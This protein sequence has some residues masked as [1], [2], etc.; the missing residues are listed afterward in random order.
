MDLLTQADVRFVP[1]TNPGDTHV[2]LFMPTHRFGSEVQGDPLRWK[3]LVTHV[4]T[5]LTE[6][7]EMSRQKAND[8]LAPAWELQQDQLAWQH[9]SDGL[10][11][12]L[13]AHWQRLLRSP[14]RIPT[15]GAVGDRFVVGP[16]LRSV[17]GD[18]RFLLLTLSQRDIRLFEGTR[19]RMDPVELAEVP[20]SLSDVIAVPDPRSDTMTRALGG[21]RAVFYGHGAG[22]AHLKSDAVRRFLQQVA[23]GLDE[24]LADQDLPMVLVGLDEMIGTYRSVN[25]YP[26]VLDEDVRHNPDRLSAEELHTRVWPLL[27]RHLRQRHEAA[28]ERFRQ[29]H[30]TGRASAQLDEVTDAAPQSRIETLFLSADPW[31]WEQAVPTEPTIVHLGFDPAFADCERLD[32]AAVHTLRGGGHVYTV[33]SSELPHAGPA[34]AVFRY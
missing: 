24:Y 31:C 34:A 23:S 15:V 29:L 13:G 19:D 8:L 30:G 9:M 3:N 25:S 2:S 22:D 17:S 26:H 16:L 1:D 33:A 18:A 4:Q 12:Y 7:A 21:S 28:I 27:E 11:F 14:V 6:R 5:V 20:S 10:V 32:Q